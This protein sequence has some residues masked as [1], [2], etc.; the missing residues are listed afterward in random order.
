MIWGK[1]LDICNR[2]LQKIAKRQIS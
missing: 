1:Y 2:R